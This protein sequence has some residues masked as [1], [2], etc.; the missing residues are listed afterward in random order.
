MK[1]NLD[2]VR[3]LLLKIEEHNCSEPIVSRSIEVEG[4]NEVEIGLHLNA[5]ADAGF[6]V[7]E[8]YRTETG[9]LIETAIIFDLTWKGHEYLDTIRD[10]AIWKKTKELSQK[11][12]NAAFEFS[13][14]IAKA[15][16]K[17]ALSRLGLDLA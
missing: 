4:H 15:V 1:R 8:G 5:M 9:R 6:L 3:T 13:I 16:A 14:E 11:S 10:P 7:I 17:Q 2:L 12:G